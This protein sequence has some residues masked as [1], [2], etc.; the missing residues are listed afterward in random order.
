[1]K[2][3]TAAV[4]V[5]VLEAA[6][7]LQAVEAAST[8]AVTTRTRTHEFIDVLALPAILGRITEFGFTSNLSAK[9][10]LNVVLLANLL[11]SSWLLLGFLRGRHPYADLERWQTA[12]IPVYA[13]W[14]A[15]V[16]VA[17]PLLFDFA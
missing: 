8:Q 2:F 7:S 14:A 4:G 5:A 6:G 17:F 13:A 3:G 9:L 11:W 10:G 12:Y 15:V 1:M 16:V